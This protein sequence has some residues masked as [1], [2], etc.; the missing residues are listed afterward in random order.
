MSAWT[1]RR[2]GTDSSGRGIFASDYMWA[3]WLLV[4]AHPLVKPFAHKI[5]ITQGAWMTLAGGGANDSAGYHDGGGCF[6]IRVWNLTDAEVRTLIRVLRMFGIAAWLRNLE[7]GGFK[8]AHIHIVLGTDHDLADGAAWQWSEYRAGR[9]GL[10]SAGPDY[11]WRP[12]PL[13]TTPPE[14]DMY[15]AEDTQRTHDR[16]LNLQRV[17]KLRFQ[18]EQT[19][20]A[21]QVADLKAQLAKAQATLD[22]IRG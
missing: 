12:T 22:E 11:H 21:K 2:R 8:D 4:L 9:N 17:E 19:T 15:T 6:D 18:I 16:V 3:V 20:D 13:V 5:T 14:D 1:V 7:H 10:A